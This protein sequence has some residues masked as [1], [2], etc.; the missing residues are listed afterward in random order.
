MDV[1]ISESP[2]G[3]PPAL[4][5]GRFS[6]HAGTFALL[7]GPAEK[8][9]TK[10]TR[11]T[12]SIPFFHCLGKNLR[13]VGSYT[14]QSSE[15][16]AQIQ[17]WFAAYDAQHLVVFNA[18]AL[19]PATMAAVFEYAATVPT[20]TF[21]CEPGAY[22]RTRAAVHAA[23]VT[24]TRL[25]W[26]DLTDRLPVI[27]EP[28]QVVQPGY[29]LSHLPVTD[30]LLF[31]HG[32]RTLNTPERFAAIDT[33]YRAAY[34][35]ALTI[36]PDLDTVVATLAKVT[37]HATVTAPIMVS[38]R[39]TQAALLTR[40]WLLTAHQ[41]KAMG[42]LCSVR[43]PNPT[44]AHWRALHGYVRTPRVAGVTL[45]LLDVPPGDLNTVTV[46]EVETYLATGCVGDQPIPDLARPLLKAH[47]H[48]RRSE[49]ATSDDPYLNQKGPR[50]HL[51]DLIDARR[52]LGIPIDARNLHGVA[53]SHTHR[54]I[55][56]FGL[57][58]RDMT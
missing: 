34:T 57:E 12:I 35:A 52:H 47:L 54:A 1:F 4:L 48:Y 46:G 19:Y 38:M 6:P 11:K 23:G 41:D 25:D 29:D 40:G 20:I 32:A 44:E 27:A 13:T 31:R 53:L 45:Y 14:G 56:R 58:L 39:A 50:R 18:A 21:V 24:T 16:R 43:S 42:T 8:A 3:N 49:G 37:R 26:E 15:F 30:F 10:R 5:K 51:E 2:T 28:A 36:E 17:H 7:V 22:E 9:R 33:D 55:W